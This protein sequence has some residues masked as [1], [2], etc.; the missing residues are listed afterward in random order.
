MRR[1]AASARR[2]GS[3]G[4]GAHSNIWW[5][6][7]GLGGICDACKPRGQGSK[8]HRH[9]SRSG[10]QRIEHHASCR[11]N[12]RRRIP[13]RAGLYASLWE[14]RLC[15]IRN[16]SSELGSSLIGLAVKAWAQS[17]KKGRSPHRKSGATGREKHR[18]EDRPLREAAPVLADA[19]G[20]QPRI[21]TVAD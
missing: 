12:A 13:L 4:C 18:S 6:A 3:N 5:G 17:Q 7:H 14:P 8:P 9:P 19:A 1:F 11:E 10:N 21:S 16:G 15:E 20:S 2:C